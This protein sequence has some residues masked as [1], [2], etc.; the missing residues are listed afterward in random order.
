MC[1]YRLKDSTYPVALHPTVA[2]TCI[3]TCPIPLPISKKS[4]LIPRRLGWITQFSMKRGFIAPYMASIF[5]TF[6][7]F[8]F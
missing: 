8:L 2:A 5:C 1:T 3:T 4:L 7:L 6:F